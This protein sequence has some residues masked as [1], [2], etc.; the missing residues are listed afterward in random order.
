MSLQLGVPSDLLLRL[1]SFRR[2]A[3]PVNDASHHAADHAARHTAFDTLDEPSAR[4]EITESD[5]I[6][7]GTGKMRL[8]SIEGDVENG[9]LMCGQ[10]AGLIGEVKTCRQIVEETVAQAEAVIARMPAYVMRNP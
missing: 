8:G 3:G 9:S 10:I 6:E 2:H 5:L 7:F 4:R 1:R